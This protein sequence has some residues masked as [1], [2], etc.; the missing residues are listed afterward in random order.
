MLVVPIVHVGKS[1]CTSSDGMLPQ[2]LLLKI[3]KD[4]HPGKSL[5]PKMAQYDKSPGARG[6][7]N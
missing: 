5:Q 3:A 1:N 2:A 4:Y 6:N 7:G